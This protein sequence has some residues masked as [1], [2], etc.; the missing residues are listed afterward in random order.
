MED[1]KIVPFKS[2]KRLN[3]NGKSANGAASD[4]FGTGG[5]YIDLEK[6]RLTFSHG[7]LRITRVVEKGTTSE[8][9][10][11]RK[12]HLLADQFRLAGATFEI[13]RHKTNGREIPDTISVDLPKLR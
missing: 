1:G 5:R 10:W 11:G 9:D 3:G 8:R 4:V 13:F 12:V 7:K 2:R 6:V